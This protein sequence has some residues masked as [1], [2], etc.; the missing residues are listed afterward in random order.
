MET[1]ITTATDKEGRDSCVVVVK[2]TFLIN[3]NG[4]A[5][6]SEKQEPFVYADAH[7]GDPGET[8]IQ[9][10][11][12]FAP[13]KPRTDIIIN[14]SAYAPKERPVQEIA[15]SFQVGKIKKSVRVVGD[16]FWERGILK[17]LPSEPEPFV[18]M[19]LM[20]EKAYGGTDHSHED[21]KYHGTEMRNPVGVGFF[22]NPNLRI[23][24]GTP[25]PNIEEPGRPINKYTDNPGPAGFGTLGRN[26]HPRIKYAGTYDD[27]W[28]KDKFPFLPDDFDTQYFQSAPAD[29][30]LDYLHGGEEVVCTNM[31]PDGTLKFTIPQVKV[32]LLFRFTDK[33]V[34]VKPNLDTLIIEPDERRFILI[35]RANVPIGRKLNALR[36]I[37]VGMQPEPEAPKWR[38]AKRYFK[39]LSEFIDWKKDLN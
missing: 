15:A 1:G 28:L 2:G 34:E 5:G 16:R 37:L 32:P 19:P 4:V 10:E 14:G 21:P 35:W 23:V 12:D 24:E 39:S 30:Q 6:L 20:F 27:G 9:Y 38:N 11:C 36:E 25:L 26:W 33:E 18:K 8:S 22:K 7:Y 31:T 3:E 29:Q 13:F 17:L